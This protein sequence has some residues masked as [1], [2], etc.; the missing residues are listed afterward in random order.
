MYEIPVFSASIWMLPLASKLGT[1]LQFDKTNEYSTILW[2]E[3]KCCHPNHSGHLILNMVL[4]YCMVEEERSMISSNNEHSNDATSIE[5]DFTA[6]ERPVLR[7]PIYLSMEE[8]IVYVESETDQTYIDF[9]N[10]SSSNVTWSNIISFNDGWQYYA[11]NSDEDKYGFIADDVKGGPHISFSLAVAM[12]GSGGTRVRTHVEISY[13]M[14]YENFGLA[15]AWLSDSSERRPSCT[16][17]VDIGERQPI[18]SGEEPLVAYWNE[19]SSVPTVVILNATIIEGEQRQSTLHL[20]LTPRNDNLRGDGHNKF[21]LLGI[22][23][24]PTSHINEQ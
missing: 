5:H 10:P 6:D 17:P 21:K 4:A 7:D 22:R 23:L 15:Y 19:P 3:G 18:I 14:S 2:H 8:E 9:T 24:F 12:S 16:K 1:K 13:T 20:C 11:D